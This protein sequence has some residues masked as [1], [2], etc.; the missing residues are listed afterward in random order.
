M[1]ILAVSEPTPDGVIF[2]TMEG[3]ADPVP[4]RFVGAEQWR[5]EYVSEAQ[6]TEMA[7]VA[8]HEVVAKRGDLPGTTSALLDRIG[9]GALNEIN[10]GPRNETPDP[11]LAAVMKQ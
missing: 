8:Q 3:I 4:V 11:R 5:S 9:L 10:T 1:T 2:L 7:C 6:Q